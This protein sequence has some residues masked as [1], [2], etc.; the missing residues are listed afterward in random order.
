VIRGVGVGRAVE[1]TD[2]GQGQDQGP[3][4]LKERRQDVVA[5]SH[6]QDPLLIRFLDLLL[7]LL[8]VARVTRGVSRAV[9]VV[10]DHRL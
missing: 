6:V 10:Q 4:R 9:G 2:Q 3:H 7:H 1:V 5:L 8:A